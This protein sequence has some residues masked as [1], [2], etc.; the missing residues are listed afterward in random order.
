MDIS[1]CPISFLLY[2]LV[3]IAIIWNALAKV[4]INFKTNCYKLLQGVLQTATIQIMTI[5]H[6]KRVLKAL[7]YFSYH[8]VIAITSFIFSSQILKLFPIFC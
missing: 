5:C 6:K 3:D 8:W 7:F 1:S 4:G 2:G